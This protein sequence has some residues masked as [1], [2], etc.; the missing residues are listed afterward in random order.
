M[1]ALVVSFYNLHSTTALGACDA[2]TVCNGPAESNK[3]WVYKI[4]ENGECVSKCRSWSSVPH[5]ATRGYACGRC[6]SDTQQLQQQEFDI[7]PF[8]IAYSVP[9]LVSEHITP[10]DFDDLL[11]ATMDFFIV[12]LSEYYAQ[13]PGGNMEFTDFDLAISSTQLDSGIPSAQYNVFCTFRGS[14]F[15]SPESTPPPENV[16]AAMLQADFIS[17]L[18]HNVQWIPAFAS[19]KEMHIGSLS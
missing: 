5:L 10:D 13:V 1:L 2:E 9:K 4:K 7:Q 3:F 8:Y 12:Y 6:P 18:I 14:A 11:Q 16:Y 19:T 15:F 17:Y